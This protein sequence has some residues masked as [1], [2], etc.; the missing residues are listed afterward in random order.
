MNRPDDIGIGG[1]ATVTAAPPAPAPPATHLPSPLTL[2]FRAIEMTDDQLVQFCADNRE[3][4]IELT[5][6]KELIIMPP[7]N[8]TTGWQNG[9][10]FLRIGNWA[11]QDGSGLCFDSSSGFTLPN[12][13]MRSSDA[14]WIAWER[15]E[16]LDEAER[17]RFSHIAPDFAAE[18]RSQSDRLAT[19]QSKM[20]EY[21]ENGVRLGW[22]IDPRQ[23]RVYVYRPGQ[24]VETLE[25]PET[26]SGEAVLPGFTLNLREIWQ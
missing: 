22:L 6:K 25:N 19:L 3:L 21:I 4:R 18:L 7:A 17:Y 9:K 20:A 11:E 23:R 10:L 14:A 5:A 26:V 16:S 12:G 13:A 1:G 8:M 15:W 2:D 24:S